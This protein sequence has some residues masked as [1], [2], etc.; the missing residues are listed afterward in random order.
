MDIGNPTI[1]KCPLC[2]KKM[3]MTNWTSYTVSSSKSYSDG[4]IKESGICCPGFTPDLAKCPHC[5]KLFFRHKV[6]DAQTVNFYTNKV[7]KDIEDPVINDLI[8][9]VK[10]KEFKK[11]QDEKAIREDLWR[12][13]NRGY[14]D[15][16]LGGSASKIRHDNC[17]ALLKLTKKTLKEIQLEKN[18]KKYKT[19]DRDDCLLMIAEL[20][21]NLGNFEKCMEI[22]NTLGGKWSWLKKQ[23]AW[24]CKAKNILTFELI[25]KSEMNLEK[26]EEQ[27]SDDYYKRAKKFLNISGHKNIKKA[28]A[29]Y[30]RAEELGMR[31]TAFYHERGDIYLDK[32]NDPDSAI[33]DF[34]KAL[35][36][37]DKDEWSK[38][39]ISDIYRQRSNAYCKK[40]NL[41]K[42][43]A[44]IQTAIEEDGNYEKLYTARAIIYEAMGKTKEAENDKRK[45]EEVYRQNL[46]LLNKQQ[47]EWKAFKKK[48]TKTSA[49]KGIVDKKLIIKKPKKRG[50]SE[51]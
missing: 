20:N 28:V 5:K 32:L 24:E 27:Y 19:E 31:G 46:E 7:K 22:I 11:W 3:Q 43:F 30:K 9:A 14:E 21:R 8:K 51:L 2:G 49:K 10:N 45:A 42:A 15:S 50:I 37:K 35:K 39:Y 16:D 12:G 25:T 40:S 26:A 41:K 47:E 29:D 38:S 4:Y 17:S 33:A 44:D 34:T 23:F 1:Y 6:K 48:H 13:L 18:N 36:Q